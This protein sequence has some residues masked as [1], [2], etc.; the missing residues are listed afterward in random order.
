MSESSECGRVL[1][2]ETGKDKKC[3]QIKSCLHCTNIQ[4]VSKW[5]Q[6]GSPQSWLTAH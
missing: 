6:S 1:N 4:T 3:T 2:K 5:L